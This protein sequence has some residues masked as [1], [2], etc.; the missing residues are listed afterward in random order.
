[1]KVRNLLFI[2]ICFALAACRPDL[3]FMPDS[4]YSATAEIWGDQTEVSL[5]FPAD[6]GSASVTF[7]SNKDWTLS[8]VNDRAKDWCSVPFEGGH[9]GTYTMRVSVTPNGDYDERSATI[10]L[11]CGELL[12][13]IVVT[14]KQKDALL[15]SPGRVELSPEGGTFTI[16][17][18][19]NIDYSVTLPETVSWIHTV[20]TK[21]L[22]ATTRTFRV[23]ANENI[24]PR[25]GSI[26]VSSSL[27][28]EEVTVYQAGEEPVLVVS[29]H[30]VDMP[31][32]GG[33]FAVQVT[34][35]LNVEIVSV[36]DPCDWVEEIQT[37]ALST[38]TYYYAVAPNPSAAERTMALVFR[39]QQLGLADTVLVRQA[40]DR[41]LVSDTLA[42]LPS[43]EIRF[44]VLVDGDQPE[45]YQ[46]TLSHRWLWMGERET[47]EDYSYLWLSAQANDGLEPRTGY[48]SLERKGVARIDSVT[49]IQ[50]GRMPGFSF[51]TAQREVK[52]PE[53]DAKATDVWI[54]WGDGSFERY[55]ADAIHRYAESG[56][57]DIWVEG[58]SLA[59]LLIPAPADGMKIDFS[60]LKEKEDEE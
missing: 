1:M 37:K 50:S 17:V 59:P 23:D 33:A 26:M 53:L 18:K 29:E 28:K 21:G 47:G 48:V 52:A 54:L 32:S 20:S 10:V 4:F 38:N 56:W 19:A 15:L 27:G 8:F 34:S 49:V 60:G 13:T 24:G 7:E 57:H 25:Q 30:E 41:I 44:A 5:V 39:N 46:V 9:D 42:E 45:E 12:R 2:T 6:A 22:V 3:H 43:R 35:N 58:R 11:S 31:A 14:Q 16:E 36:P 51:S 55:A 40:F